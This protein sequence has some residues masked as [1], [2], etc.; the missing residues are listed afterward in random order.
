M[1]PT[2]CRQAV[3]R[4]SRSAASTCAR[5]HG[6]APARPAAKGDPRV[7][8]PDP[9]S[10]SKGPRRVLTGLV[11]LAA[12]LLIP[13]ASIRAGD[14]GY[15]I[16]GRY[17]KT[18]HLV[19]MR[20]G[21]RLH[22]TVYA[23]RH[24]EEK[25]PFLLLRTPYGCGPYGPDAY[26]G[27]LG[28]SPHSFEFEEEG[29][30]F[31]FQDVRGRFQSEGDF[32]VMRPHRPRKTGR[33]TDESSDTY[34]TI[35]WLLANIPNHNGRVGMIGTSYPGFQVVHGLL[36]PHPALKA[37]SP[38]AP[39]LDMFIGDDF[40]HNGAFRL[41]YSF[42]WLGGNAGTRDGPFEKN[43]KSFTPPTPDGYQF[44][45]DLGPLSNADANYFRGQ[46][47]EWNRY[48]AHPD[49]DAYWREQDVS[50]YLEGVR[51]PTLLVA[52]W[53]DAEDFY[54][55]MTIY[56]RI[57]A[58]TPDNRSTLVVG[59]FSHGG[60]NDHPDGN[61]LG[62]I[63]FAGSPCVEFRRNI[64][65]P[66]FRHHLK[67]KGDLDL[68][69]AYVYETGANRWR[70]FDRWPPRDR[71]AER[72][73]YLRADGRLAFEPPPE[74]DDGSDSYISD[75]AKPVP[76]TA[77]IR[78]GNGHLWM[79]EDQ[80]FAAR[81]PDVL[82]YQ[83]DPLL[84]D[85]TIAGAPIA[86]L[87][88]S[89]TGTDADLVAKLIDVYPADAADGLGGY[90]MLLSGEVFRAKYRNSFA[91]PEPLTPGRP[92]ALEIDLRDK[93]HRFL[94][95]HRIMLQVQSTWFPVIDVNPGEF[96]DIYSFT[97]DRYRK[98]T[99]TV[100]RGRGRSSHVSLPVLGEALR[101]SDAAAPVA[102]ATTTA[103]QPR[104]KRP[105]DP[106]DG[107]PF[108]TARAWA[109][110]DGRT[111][112]VLN[113]S[114]EAK[115]LDPASTTKMM[116]ALVVMRLARA[117][118]GVLDEAV[119]FSERADK[120]PGS[121]ADVHAG[122]RLPVRELLYGLLLPS[123]NDAS[124]A[125]AEHFGGRLAPPAD[126]PGEADPLPRFVAEMNRVAAELGLGETHFV[127]PNGLTV[128][129]HLSSARDLAK[130]ARV[131]LA[132][133]VFAACV[134]TREHG[135]TLIDPEGRGRD[136]VWTNTNHLLEIEGYDGVKT[137]T[138]ETA[139]ACLVASGRRGQD[140]LIVVV[141]G[142]SSPEARYAEA[143]NL[144]RWAWQ[145]RGHRGP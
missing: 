131:A 73:L 107:P 79:V 21:V 128:K 2:N 85:L 106:L 100:H 127:N 81:R 122:E 47:P 18:E 129:G 28:P 13:A 110:A 4:L 36:D 33:E 69:E 139:G 75:P 42:I 123:G 95:G 144:F 83:S 112:E 23:P 118:P 31:V 63:K 94:K 77:E 126:S 111:G 19:P 27:H 120:T 6:P 26:R 84:E 98:V 90:Q 62:R 53:F 101:A 76:A 70:S 40:H 99:Q 22:T 9:S 64:Q 124:V 5:A 61:S 88:V 37:A 67:G 46:V 38:Q 143:R 12:I 104:A 66:F 25:L 52:G 44:F 145:A 140:H 80:R 29:F 115:P 92:A 103:A 39:P 87:V 34:D 60:W 117:D 138:T 141:L 55:P 119:V 86:K 20:D 32:L 142:S 135:G 109:V 51:I 59:P 58:T 17:Q 41:A 1:I 78:F 35:E 137:G 48:M 15:D 121:T 116:T 50:P 43:R 3:A 14:E 91:R 11:A 108:V 16:K 10:G 130:L 105:P 93:F 102:P 7:R 57:E 56:R 125:L 8:S 68:P 30:I 97:K 133:P 89:S 114:A 74:G 72:K 82:V 54:G 49:Y 71:T 45:L 113:G 136:V 96:G 134:A 24:L 65:F 132:E